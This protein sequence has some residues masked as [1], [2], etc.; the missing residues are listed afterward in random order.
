MDVLYINETQILYWTH[1]THT[2]TPRSTAVKSNICWMAIP[3]AFSVSLSLFSIIF[4]TCVYSHTTIL[5][6][7][8]FWLQFKWEKNVSCLKRLIKKLFW[9]FFNI[10]TASVTSFKV[11]IN[12]VSKW[13]YTTL[14]DVYCIVPLLHCSISRK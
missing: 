9:C 5:F 8:N 10:L 7:S 2:H 11:R 1:D 14:S 4:F 13:F 12:F 6:L 3:L